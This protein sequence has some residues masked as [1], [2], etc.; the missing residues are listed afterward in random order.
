LEQAQAFRNGLEV[1]DWLHWFLDQVVEACTQSEQIVRRTLAKGAFWSR[2]RTDTIND[3]QRKALN[4]LLDAGPD[5][6]QGGMTNRKYA[7]LTRCSPVTAS[8][9]LTELAS[10]GCLVSSGAGRSTTY[11][12]PWH[13]LLDR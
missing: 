5:G 9:D 2:H 11:G 12:I 4:R 8:R 10:L 6:F 13:T 3:R 7:S 1:T